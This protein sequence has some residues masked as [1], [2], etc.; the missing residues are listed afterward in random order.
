MDYFTKAVPAP[1]GVKEKELNYFKAHSALLGI[2][3]TITDKLVKIVEFLNNKDV[4]I[5]T[6]G[7]RLTKECSSAEKKIIANFMIFK[8][9]HVR[10]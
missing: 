9:H 1:I 6:I 3:K 7:M 8:S 2:D 10:V 4:E 5:R